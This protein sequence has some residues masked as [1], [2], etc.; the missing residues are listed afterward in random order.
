MSPQE[1]VDPVDHAE[2]LLLD[3]HFPALV[4]ESLR[5][6]GFD[7]RAVVEEPT[8]VGLPDATLFALAASRGWRIVT[9]NVRDFRP[10]LAAALAAVQP[11]APL[12]LTTARRHPR[13][14]AAVGALT[15]A[16]AAWLREHHPGPEQWL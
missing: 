1:A 15:Q 10:L 11:Y 4:A 13:H 9:E 12:L 16:L 8:L 6:Q 7:V 5:A 14:L 2:P 3:E